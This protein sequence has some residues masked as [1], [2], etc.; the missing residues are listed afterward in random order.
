MNRIIIY[1]LLLLSFPF[2]I[3][4][5]PTIEKEVEVKEFDISEIKLLNELLN[6]L[7]DSLQQ[8][9]LDSSKLQISID[10]DIRSKSLNSVYIYVFDI[11]KPSQPYWTYNELKGFISLGPYTAFFE[12]HKKYDCLSEFIKDTPPR[13]FTLSDYWKDP[14]IRLSY[15]AE[16]GTDA[17]SIKLKSL[18]INANELHSGRA[19]E[20]SKINFNP[21]WIITIPIDHPKSTE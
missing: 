5:K 18:S 16:S 21:P 14:L 4:G 3:N 7:A 20:I 19:G 1:L 11:E 9:N 10:L 2:V 8:S 6:E 13:R 17:E 12:S 15:I